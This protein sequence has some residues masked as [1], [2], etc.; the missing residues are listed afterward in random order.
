[1]VRQRPGEAYKPQCL[2]PTV[3]AAD[4]DRLCYVGNNFGPISLKCNTLCK[5]FVGVLDKTTGRM[6]IHNAELF[7]MQP[8][9]PG[10]SVTEEA[11]S[12]SQN[13][14]YREKVDSLIE[15]FGT[16]K[17]K[18][19]LGTRRM[20]Q[21]GSDTLQKAV[22]KAAENII[23]KK[24]VT[25][26]VNDVA[27]TEAQDA[28]LFIPPCQTAATKPEDVYKFDDLISPAEYEA[29]ATPAKAFRDILSEDIPK[30]IEEGSPSFV[31]EELKC[32]PMNDE[33]RDHKARCLW[34]LNQL[35]KLSFMK[36]I[37]HKFGLAD[38]C[39][40]LIQ[41]KLMKNFTFLSFNSGSIQ[42]VVSSSMKSKISAYVLALALHINDFQ[43]DLTL[44]Q[45]DMKLS[46]NKMLEIAKAMGLKITKRSVS[47]SGGVSEDHKFG[48]LVL[49]LLKYDQGG[50]QR[51]RKRMA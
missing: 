43:T 41:S 50:N 48:T 45:R 30:M 39:P 10:E 6:E 47:V 19:A 51:K 23:D 7:N 34:Y 25:A 37:K 2:T 42:N 3:K 16:N 33:L 8:V 18:R 21:V 26:L 29:S 32:M 40:R 13:K 49:P 24:G 4:T 31:V 35:I 44:L 22:A 11:S 15:A 12:E 27:Q 5:Y 9:F 20:N 36:V 17:Q 46:E 28:V 38:T 1:M 14:S